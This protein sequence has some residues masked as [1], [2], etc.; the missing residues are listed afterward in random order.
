MLGR[1]ADGALVKERRMA[2]QLTSMGHSCVR[3]TTAGRTLVIDPGAYSER[4]SIDGAEAVLITH[5]HPDHFDVD[6]LRTAAAA[7]PRLGIW[8]NESIAGMLVDL[9]G[10]VHTVSDGASFTAAGMDVTVHGAWHATIHPDLPPTRNV[11]FLVGSEVFHPGDSFT[12]P[13]APAATVLLPVYAP[14]M[15]LSE[16]IQF[17]RDLRPQRLIAIHDG[18]LNERGFGLVDRLLGSTLVG[19]DGAIPTYRHL[20]AGTSIEL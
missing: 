7:D 12:Q 4:T 5:E 19:V 1:F 9:G 18:M 16:A 15:K 3:L 8:T 10:R 2:M 13:G 11:C 20:A 17:A 14:W 6:L